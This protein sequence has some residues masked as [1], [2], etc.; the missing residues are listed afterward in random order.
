MQRVRRRAD[1][2]GIIDAS[3]PKLPA[4]RG[5]IANLSDVLQ[6]GRARLKAHP[7]ARLGPGLITGVADDDPSGIATYSQ[8]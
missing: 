3:R 1:R 5:T 2:L 6:S 8:A 4:R 7:L